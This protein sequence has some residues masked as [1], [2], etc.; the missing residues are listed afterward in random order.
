MSILSLIISLV[1]VAVGDN[2]AGA[3]M[4]DSKTIF[5]IDDLKEAL[6]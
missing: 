6:P 3:A 2:V 4:K 1:G 5:G